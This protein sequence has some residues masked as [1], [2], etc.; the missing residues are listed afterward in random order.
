MSK[1]L[2]GDRLSVSALCS[3]L[4]ICHGP[5]LAPLV[6]PGFDIPSMVL[7]PCINRRMRQDL[8]P[9]FN[10]RFALIFAYQIKMV[11]NCKT[12]IKTPCLIYSKGGLIL[13][14]FSLWLK[15]AK[16]SCQI[17]ILSTLQLS[18]EKMHRIV[19]WHLFFL[20]WA[21]KNKQFEIKPRLVYSTLQCSGLA[22][23]NSSKQIT[24]LRRL[25]S[26]VQHFWVFGLAFQYGRLIY[27][28]VKSYHNK[29]INASL[30]L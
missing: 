29:F 6:H 9:P 3:I 19:I 21:K 10:A 20:I 17:T 14:R 1:N 16:Q 28:E 2:G 12:R 25:R 22:C 30:I 8:F 15:S 27:R 13:E 24:R 5:P 26:S 11:G 23:M 18:K 7:P 4:H